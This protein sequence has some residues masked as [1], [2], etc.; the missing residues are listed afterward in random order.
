[1][2]GDLDVADDA[3]Q[4]AYCAVLRVEHLARVE[5]LRAYVARVHIHECTASAASSARVW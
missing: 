3:L 1:M 4:S 5:N 2:A